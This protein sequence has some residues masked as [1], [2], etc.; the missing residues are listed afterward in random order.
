MPVGDAHIEAMGA[1]LADVHRT[2][3]SEGPTHVLA[4]FSAARDAVVTAVADGIGLAGLDGPVL[5]GYMVVPTGGGGVRLATR[6]HAAQ[7]A[8]ARP[9]YRAMYGA[10]AADLVA[11]GRTHHS[12]PVLSRHAAVVQTFFELEFGVDQIDGVLF[13]PDHHARSAPANAARM[14]RM[15]TESDVDRVVELAIELNEYHWQSPMFQAADLDLM[16]IR[17]SVEHAIGDERSAVVVLEQD[18]RVV[19]MAQAGPDSSYRDALD[20]GMNV[21]TA[22]DRST[23]LGTAILDFLLEWAASR[24]YR[25][26]TVGWTSSN[27]VSDAFYRSRGFRPVRYRLHRHVHPRRGLRR[28]G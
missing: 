2:G 8:Q 17:Q 22:S 18:G 16:F 10:L 19:A 21:V 11:A 20:I 24:E 5:V 14:A 23:G 25:Y 6:H 12:L 28:D 27:P 26:C 1:V 4:D 3:S 13:V 15:A 7:L 9:L